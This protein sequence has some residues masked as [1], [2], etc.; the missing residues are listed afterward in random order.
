ML[1]KNFDPKSFEKSY[2]FEAEASA[3]RPA[4][5]PFMVLLPP[6]N[7]TGVLHIGHALCF[8]LQDI[9]V[10][11]RRLK[12]DDVLFQ[13]G[14]D[15][16]G[17]VTQLLVEKNLL[18]KGV[19][20][21]ELTRERLLDEIWKWQEYSRNIILNQMK[22]LGISCDFTRTKFTM[23]LD[24]Q[25]AVT[26]LFVRL[27]EDGLIYRG[28]KM[29]NWDP[30]I[31]SAISDLEVQEKE[32]D[33]HLWYIKY[34]FEG[35]QNEYIEVATTRPETLFGDVAVAINPN[36][37][38]YKHLIGKKVIVPIINKVV[39]IIADEYA[40]PEKGSG[41][42]KI[43]P[44]HDFNDFAVGERHNLEVIDVFTDKAAL[45]ENVPESFRGMDRF[46]AR[47]LVVQQL[48]KADL[49]TKTEAIKQT[50][51]FGDR[52]G[53]IL[54]PRITNQW[55]VNAEK[56]A[57]PAIEAVKDGRI[58]FVPKHWE[59]L[60]FEWLENIQPWCISRQ[61][62]WGHKVPAWYG[63]DGQVFVAKNEEQAK[64]KARKVYG[65]DGNFELI[66]DNDVLDTWFSSGMWPF[67][68]Q[69]W[70]KDT[71]YLRR[72]Y[73]NGLL[74]TGFDIIF[75]W[76]ARMIMMGLYAMNNVPFKTVYIH[77]LVR[78]S[79]GQKMSKSKGNVI[80]PLVLSDKYGAD[81]L[82]YTLASL[83]SPGRDIR[84]SEKATEFGRNFLTKLWNTTRFAEMNN[85]T[86]DAK[87]NPNDVQHPI[88]QWIVY[89][90]KNLITKVD[91]AF[92]EYRFDNATRHIYQCLWGEFCDWYVE[93]IKPLLQ[94]SGENTESI[95]REICSTTAWA[96]VQMVQILYPFTPFISKKLC[97]EFGVKEIVWPDE[98]LITADFSE[99]VKQVKILKEIINSVRSMKKYMGIPGGKKVAALLETEDSF[100]CKIV[101]DFEKTINIMAGVNLKNEIGENTIPVVVGTAVI[102]IELD[103]K[104][105]VAS[106]LQR[107]DK[108]ILKLKKV[109][110]E[111]LKRLGN[112]DFM[113]KASEEVIEEQKKRVE[114]ANQKLEGIEAVKK[115][116]E[117][118]WMRSN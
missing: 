101:Q 115:S 50:V 114:E 8:T 17:I 43:T 92:Y 2:S 88:S 51:P 24:C 13:P 73:S 1:E 33:G 69:G 68:T 12:G 91:E 48:E 80:D 29:V 84:M 66:P 39:P 109:K 86:Y 96:I 40:D 52:S 104:L 9:V 42:V 5:T 34:M 105:D 46:E 4:A 81:A 45:N 26:E 116:L 95:K 36:D 58:V 110:E 22:A 118:S 61:I 32:I 97:E 59:N 20:R 82:R 7:V 103:E 28:K 54:E 77:S 90:I 108:E 44:A 57:K 6:P 53:V 35:S 75:F 25:E 11:Y 93:F 41:A 85:C 67:T 117:S 113:D 15:H 102:R 74:V 107:L 10:R 21:A 99:S 19:S 63:P 47:S 3:R 78:D 23:D 89:E 72:F 56:L 64:E 106:E 79:K 98:K 14:L 18:A 31:C 16:A 38:K 49:I 83:V 55:F 62:W 70:P 60:Y 87:F 100:V 27:Y 112:R 65:S 30:M 37:E 94:E 111:S 76:V 71:D